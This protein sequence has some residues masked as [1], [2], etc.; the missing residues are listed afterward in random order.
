MVS[1]ATL[2]QL[3]GQRENKWQEGTGGMHEACVGPSE[4]SR[5]GIKT[6]KGPQPL[7]DPS[8]SVLHSLSFYI[9][10]TVE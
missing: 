1:V 9:T 10:V 4:S 6:P 5:G 2:G 8:L 7:V 3:C